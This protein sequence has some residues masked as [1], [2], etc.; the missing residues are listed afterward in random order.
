MAPLAFKFEPRQGKDHG[1]PSSF[2][3][4]PH[5]PNWRR[6]GQSV[7]PEEFQVFYPPVIGW[8]RLTLAAHEKNAKSVASVGFVRLPLY[9]SDELLASTKYVAVDRPPMPPLSALGLKRFAA[10]EQS[11]PDAITYLDTVFLKTGHVADEGLYFHELI[12]VVQWR[13]LGPERFLAAYADG[14]ETFGYRN[15]PLE[16]MA[17]DAQAGFAQSTKILDAEKLVA[18]KLSEMQLP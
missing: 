15:S 7:T 5:R 16:A 3:R 1:P 11:D 14:L 9:F 17:Y 13:V 12:H 2:H 18:E 6:E 4:P 8:I 10:F